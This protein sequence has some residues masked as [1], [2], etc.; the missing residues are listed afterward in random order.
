MNLQISKL[1][2]FLEGDDDKLMFVQNIEAWMRQKWIY[3]K[4]EGISFV[5]FC[6][7]EENTRDK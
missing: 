4:V 2:I 5:G 3:N 7:S 1:L 6:N